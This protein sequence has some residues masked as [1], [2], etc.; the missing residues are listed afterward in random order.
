MVKL[1]FKY[2]PDHPHIAIQ[3]P[4]V[5]PFDDLF[6]YISPETPQIGFIINKDQYIV[7]RQ[8]SQISAEE[9]CG[10]KR[11]PS[12]TILENLEHSNL[13]LI[14]LDNERTWYRYHHLFADL[15]RARLHEAQPDDLRELHHRAA[16]WYNQHDFAAEAIH[17][18]LAAEAGFRHVNSWMDPNRWF[19]IQLY[20]RQ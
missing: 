1:S 12:Q 5:D 7:L 18:A 3:C 10:I 17:H 20:E 4:H 19:G 9:G 2:F 16:T 6:G 13:F 15:L 11:V 14:P 8:I